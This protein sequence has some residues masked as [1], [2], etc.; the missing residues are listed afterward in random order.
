[1]IPAGDIAPPMLACNG[2]SPLAI[3]LGTWMLT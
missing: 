2:K 1:M 3:E